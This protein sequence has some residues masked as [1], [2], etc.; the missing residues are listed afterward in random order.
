M[1]QHVNALFIFIIK[2][3]D[4]LKSVSWGVRG[5]RFKSYHADHFYLKKPTTYG[6]FFYVWNFLGVILV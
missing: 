5:R 4:N 1:Q 3:L 6:W 2:V